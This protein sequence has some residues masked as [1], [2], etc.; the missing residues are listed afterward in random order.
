MDFL[1]HMVNGM[2]LNDV[3]STRILRQL[4]DGFVDDTSL[5]TNL[6]CN[7]IDLNDI[8]QLTTRLQHDML[9]WKDL[10]EASGGKLELTKCCHYILTWQFDNKGNPQP[11]TISE[12]RLVTPQIRV[13]DTF[14]NTTIVIQQKEKTKQIKHWVLYLHFKEQRSRDQLFKDAKRPTGIYD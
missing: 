10:L 3:L 1:K 7:F 9:G 11:T 14:T 13:P 12:Q 6:L 2:T 8:H 5:F 4:I